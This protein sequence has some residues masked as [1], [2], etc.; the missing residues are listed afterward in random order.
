MWMLV[1]IPLTI[2]IQTILLGPSDK[3][4]NPVKKA[5]IIFLTFIVWLFTLLIAI[6]N[7][8]FITATINNYH[9]GNIIKVETITIQGTD[10]IKVVKY[11]YK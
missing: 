10:T 3:S 2:F 11:K 8:P 4:V 6:Y 5:V 9:K 1:I 7:S